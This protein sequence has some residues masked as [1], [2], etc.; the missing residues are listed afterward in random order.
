[1]I[2]R[3]IIYYHVRGCIEE[4]ENCSGI[5]GCLDILSFLHPH[6]YATTAIELGE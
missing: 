1:M 2:N 4:N 3:S 6:A 5:C